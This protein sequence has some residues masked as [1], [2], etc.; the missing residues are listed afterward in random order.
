MIGSNRAVLCRAAL[1]AALLGGAFAGAGILSSPALAS[2]AATKMMKTKFNYTC[3]AGPASHPFAT[4]T[5][6]VT[7]E[8]YYPASVKAGQKF[9]VKWKSSN[10]VTKNLA[11]AGYALDR[12]GT[13]KAIIYEDLWP[14]TGATVPGDTIATPKKPV[15]ESGKINSPNGFYVYVKLTT[16]PQFTAGAK[17]GTAILKAGPDKS[18]ATLYSPSGGVVL[19]NEEVDC[20]PQGPPATIAKFAVT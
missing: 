20:T 11:G 19:S 1:S 3:T 10:F 8:T 7:Q 6:N 9:T 18:H 2:S 15:L 13:E 12:N 14:S 4:G 17:K 5:V 16:T